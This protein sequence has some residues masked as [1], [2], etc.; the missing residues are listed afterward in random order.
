LRQAAAS[1]PRSFR[2]DRF[3]AVGIFI[4]AGGNRL[5]VSEHCHT[6]RHVLGYLLGIFR[7]RSQ[8][9]SNELVVR[10]YLLLQA[11]ACLWHPWPSHTFIP[12]MDG[13]R[14]A[15]ARRSARRFLNLERNSPIK[16]YDAPDDR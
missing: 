8:R 15:A 7:I 16:E 11:F 1:P 6:M 9:A 5:S 2:T 10:V 3:R 14:Q 13:D 12:V 4:P